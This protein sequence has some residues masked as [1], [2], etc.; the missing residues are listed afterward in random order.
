MW[1][2]FEEFKEKR[3]ES[4]VILDPAN[5]FVLKNGEKGKMK[6][7]QDKEN[8]M[9]KELSEISNNEVALIT[10]NCNRDSTF[11]LETECVFDSQNDTVI[12][13]T[14]GFCIMPTISK[15][16]L[17]KNPNCKIKLTTLKLG[18]QQ[19]QR[20][21]LYL[22]TD[23]GESQLF[24]IDTSDIKLNSEKER[25]E[26]VFETIHNCLKERKVNAIASCLEKE[27]HFQDIC[28]MPS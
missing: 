13:I 18:K 25:F 6:I 7:E 14:Q 5:D 17:E 22:K 16:Y 20:F 11:E 2:L 3:V 28:K 1:Q 24:A 27:E 8:P 26:K 4:Y 21:G 12:V 10:Y 23:K 15:V 9:V 19:P